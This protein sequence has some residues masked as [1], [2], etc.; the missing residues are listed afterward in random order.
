MIKTLSYRFCTSLVAVLLFTFAGYS[1]TTSSQDTVYETIPSVVADDGDEATATDEESTIDTPDTLRLNHRTVYTDSV[2]AINRDKGF[3][4]KTYLDSLLRASLAKKEKPERKPVDLTPPK[5]ISSL[6]SI[7]FWILAIGLFG[8]L[9]FKLFLGDSA[10]FSRSRRNISSDIDIVSE[11]DTSDTEALLRNA[12]KAGNY[13]LAVR[14]LY[15]QSLEKLAERKFIEIN[16]N[17]TNYE[18]VS[19]VRRHK[20]ANEFASLTLQ[21]E[22]VWYGEY[23]V[24]SRLFDQIHNSFTQFNKSFPR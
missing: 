24:D 16:A 1:Q 17:K 5:P 7:I 10:I 15:I 8:F 4:Y 13:R 22:Y 6:F 18:Y 2:D 12:I 21:Y 19:E 3:Y 14:Y 23:P 9:V 11:E 20:F